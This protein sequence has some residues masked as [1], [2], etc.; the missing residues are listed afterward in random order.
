MANPFLVLGGIAVGI[1]V[2]AMG[3]LQVPGWVKS[4]QD[5]SAINDL[6]SAGIAE[7]AATNLGLGYL[8]GTE[9]G[10]NAVKLG[11]SF[12]LGSGV[13]LCVTRSDDGAAF[14]AVAMSPSGAFFARTA[15]QPKAIE[16][17]TAEE[18][19]DAIG[20]I[21]AGV[22]APVIDGD[23]A[24]DA[25]VVGTDPNAGGNGGGGGG[26]NGGGS[27]TVTPITTLAAC[28]IS[29]NSLAY[30]SNSVYGLGNGKF[31]RIDLADN[32]TH[33]IAIG[34]QA[35]GSSFA[36]INRIHSD[37]DGNLY[38]VGTTNN[39]ND[40]TLY[41]IA[42]DG[43][44]TALVA[45]SGWIMDFA[46]SPA[47]DIYWAG[48]DG[49]QDGIW[50][51]DESSGTSNFVRSESSWN[52]GSMAV[53]SSDNIVYQVRSFNRGIVKVTPDGSVTEFGIGISP[54]TGW[55]FWL[56]GLTVDGTG[57]IYFND[58]NDGTLF[59]MTTDGNQE[60][61]AGTA[62]ADYWE[63]DGAA[64][65]PDGTIFSLW[66]NSEENGIQSLKDGVRV[67]CLTCVTPPS[68]G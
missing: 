41:R 16:G 23:C 2:A 59:R 56:Q 3:V 39:G 68:A 33:E 31:L 45:A 13:K 57:D 58:L 9:L 35:E 8:N 50:K 15:G 42:P 67:P 30:A 29:A 49:G 10:D 51:L 36:S 14:A 4:A 62:D 65:A 24:P 20:G 40:Y 54:V 60:V 38:A 34:G 27:G 19:L 53:D 22:P 28:T 26:N 43:S 6:S 55:N 11:A 64:I 32:S 66:S 47:G 21:P 46:V 17:A 7:A 5:A 37:A 25:L 44:S 48:Q 1:V 18:A 63:A 12:T 52:V 61:V